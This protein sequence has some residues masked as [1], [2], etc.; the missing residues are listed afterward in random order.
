[1]DFKNTNLNPH[2]IE[3]SMHIE[4]LIY[5]GNLVRDNY[6]LY[7]R[8]V[9]QLNQWGLYQ[10]RFKNDKLNK[11]ND[12]LDSLEKKC[13]TS[14]IKKVADVVYENQQEKLLKAFPL[15]K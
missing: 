5:L 4:Q 1:M 2:C 14:A 15:L 6:P 3:I 12:S 13:L 8:N 11:L 7:N 10:E 9:L